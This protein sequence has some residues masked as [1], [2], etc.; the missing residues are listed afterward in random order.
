MPI[1]RK[2]RAKVLK[3]YIK[4]YKN[5]LYKEFSTNSEEREINPEI[6]VKGRW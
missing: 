3:L 1:T 2:D 4:I 5:S 6:Q